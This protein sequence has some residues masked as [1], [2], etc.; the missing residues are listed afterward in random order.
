[1]VGDWIEV[2][3]SDSDNPGRRDP[4]IYEQRGACHE[5]DVLATGARYH[6]GVQECPQCFRSLPSARAKFCPQCGATLPARPITQAPAAEQPRS[7]EVLR[8]PPKEIDAA[9]RAAP[10]ARPI[11][12]EKRG[13]L[14]NPFF[15]TSVGVVL[16]GTLVAGE[17][18]LRIGMLLLG[19]GLPALLVA[20]VRSLVR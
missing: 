9:P 5:R 15:L 17:G 8:Q 10:V 16:A 13:S 19:M 11:R 1:M 4:Y 18:E 12:L 14:L 3:V 7:A 6:V 20:T 2:L